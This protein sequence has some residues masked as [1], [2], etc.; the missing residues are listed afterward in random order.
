MEIIYSEDSPVHTTKFITRFF[1]RQCSYI[2][3]DYLLM[4]S[5][6]NNSNS[7]TNKLSSLIN[8]YT[9]LLKNIQLRN[10]F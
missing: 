6:N 7:K 9:S 8:Y 4:H 3:F 10:K 5:N 2:F 1:K